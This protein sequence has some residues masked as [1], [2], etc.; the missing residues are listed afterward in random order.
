MLDG[1]TTDAEGAAAW[2]GSSCSAHRIRMV[3]ET[4]G[5]PLTAARDDVVSQ[6]LRD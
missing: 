1:I 4:C 5:Q 3:H 2:H 6:I